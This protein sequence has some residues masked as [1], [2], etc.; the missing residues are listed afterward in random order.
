MIRRKLKLARSAV[1]LFLRALPERIGN[2]V[3]AHATGKYER[4]ESLPGSGVLIALADPLGVS[5]NSLV[6][7][8]KMVLEA[9]GF[10]DKTVIGDPKPFEDLLGGCRSR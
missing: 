2:R 7:D 10:N 1:S 3:T 4:N 5:V 9:L 8:W 6:D